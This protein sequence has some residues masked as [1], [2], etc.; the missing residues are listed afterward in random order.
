MNN[1]LAHIRCFAAIAIPAMFGFSEQH[2]L[3]TK[4]SERFRSMLS[5]VVALMALTFP[6]AVAQPAPTKH[7]AG[8]TIQ[9]TVLGFDGRPV[10]EAIVSLKNKNSSDVIETKSN[11]AGAFAF[12]SLSFGSYQ[13]SAGKSGLHSSSTTVV[14]SSETTIGKIDLILQEVGSSP[15]PAISSAPTAKGME[16]ADKPNF[17]VAGVT[18]WTAVGGHG[19]DSTLRTSESLASDTATLKPESTD[20]SQAIVSGSANE[21][22]EAKLRAALASSPGSFDPNHLLGKLYLDKEQY[23]EAIPLLESASRINPEDDENRYDLALAYEGFGNPSQARERIREL[24][25]NRQSADLHRLV[26]ELDEKLGDPLSA[27]HEYEQAVKLSPSE[28]NYFEWGSELLLHRAVWQAQEVFRKGGDEYPKSARMQTGLGT[29]LF[30]GAR[31]DEAALHLCTASDLKP[32][33]PNPYIFMGKI[34]MAAPNSLAC[35]EPKLA[36]FVQQQPESSIANYLYA[37]SIL[38][39]QEQQPDKQAVQQ[40]ETLLTKAV[41]IDSKCSEAYLQLGIISASQRDFDRAIILYKKAIEADPQFADAHYRLGV[42]YDRIGQPL[43]AKQELQL[44]DQI[45]Q[46]QAVETERQRREVK[47]FLIVQPGEPFGPTA[48]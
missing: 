44:H 30:A 48:K 46:Q 29:A 11:A 39:H 43:K 27:V 26:G 33:D 10:S 32:N 45:K 2:S 19:S 42:A 35:V 41:T 34:Q 22:S 40:A 20:H 24:L 7:L 36:R 1:P 16:F 23:R 21:E 15:K 31:Y 6:V 47:Q 9:G 18:D 3:Q 4:G 12:S 14:A 8:V 38:K 37:M 13:L 17:T 25:A 5:A 28:Q